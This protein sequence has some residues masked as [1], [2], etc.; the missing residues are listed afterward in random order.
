VE[1]ETTRGRE[2]GSWA[3]KKGKTCG[4]IGENPG[5][6]GSDSGESQ[7]SKAEKTNRVE[8]EKKGESSVGMDGNLENRTGGVRNQRECSTVGSALALHA[9]GHEFDSRHFQK[10]RKKRWEKKD[11]KIKLDEKE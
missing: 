11:E 2:W 7:I 4:S 8:N 3:E 10:K 6:F 1:I 9:R 5:Q